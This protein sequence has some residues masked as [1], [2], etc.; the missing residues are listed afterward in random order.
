MPGWARS[1]AEPPWFQSTRPVGRTNGAIAR[2]S[3][4]AYGPIS[5]STVSSHGRY[6][7]IA[8]CLDPRSSTIVKRTPASSA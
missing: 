6:A 2:T 3:P 7:S 8:A 1:S 4:L 5:K